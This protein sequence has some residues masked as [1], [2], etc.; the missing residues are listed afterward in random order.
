MWAIHADNRSTAFDAS[1][2]KQI[3]ATSPPEDRGAL[4][5]KI[6]FVL[7]KADLLV[8]P[9]WV[10]YRDGDTGSFAP[11]RQIR[12]RMEEKAT[13]YQEILVRPYGGLGAAETYNVENFK[14]DDPQ[15]SWDENHIRYSGFM[16]EV[17]LDRLKQKYP[18]FEAAFERIADNQ[19]VIPC[20]AQFRYNLIRLMVII[21]NKLGE[22]AIGRFQQLIGDTS[23]LDVVPV[24]AMRKFGNIVIW[25][26]DQG[27]V[28]FDLDE[29]QL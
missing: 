9:P 6:S 25:D 24:S 8:P 5:A 23:T 22:S 29:I 11:S 1:A 28:T 17:S 13:Y 18:H 4:A 21:V 15:F 16:S 14:V 2:L 7:T 10:Y 19:R 20:S 27:R 12:E 26:K 3:L